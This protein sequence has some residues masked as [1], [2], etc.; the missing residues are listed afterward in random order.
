MSPTRQSPSELAANRRP[1]V[2]RVKLW[3]DFVSPYSYL[4]LAQAEEFATRYHVCW[5]LR[6]VVYGALLDATG[7][8]GPVES[9]AKRRYTYGDVHRCAELLTVPLVG[10]A[11]HPFRSLEALRTVCVFLD[12]PESL[13]L[14]RRL[15]AACWAEG[16]MLTDTDVLRRAVQ[17]VGLDNSELETRIAEPTVKARLRAF[18]EDALQR[19]VFGVPTF[20]WSGELFWGHDRLPHLAARLDG[21][22][23]SAVEAAAEMA[24][25]PSG[26]DRKLA[27]SRP[28]DP[29]ASAD[30]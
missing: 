25:R 16:K 14:A 22:I 30:V 19:G 2:R 11:Q 24:R 28:V 1:P 17:S 27:R 20:E 29:T 9:E 12:A 15:A 5:Q 21:R 3:F 26:V 10:P 6:P 4:A 23:G 18:T 8:V 7:L 13:T